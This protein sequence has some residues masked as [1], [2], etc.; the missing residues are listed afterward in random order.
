MSLDEHKQAKH[1]ADASGKDH[2]TSSGHGDAGFG[3][4]MVHQLIES[5]EFILGSISNT[6]S[7]LR[8]WALSLAH[9]QLASVRWSHPGLPVAAHGR[10]SQDSE[11]HVFRRNRSHLGV[12]FPRN[13]LSWHFVDDG[14]PRVFLARAQASLV[15]VPDGRVEFQNKFFKGEGYRFKSFSFTSLAEN[16]NSD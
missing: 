12:L 14:R 1:P 16:P 8:L 6:A 4:L 7:Y 11:Q 15:A 13:S 10:K 9:G 2:Q 5:I 3:E